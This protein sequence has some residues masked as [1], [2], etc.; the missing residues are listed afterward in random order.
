MVK[1][2]IPHF[3]KLEKQKPIKNIKRPYQIIKK[4]LHSPPLKNNEYIKNK[5]EKQENDL[6]ANQ[7]SSLVSCTLIEAFDKGGISKMKKAFKQIQLSS[8]VGF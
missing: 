1:A 5:F 6:V 4:L 7:L 2:L 8:Q 3:E